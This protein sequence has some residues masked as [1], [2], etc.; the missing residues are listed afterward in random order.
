ML[1]LH[2]VLIQNK[3]NSLKPLL[4]DSDLMDGR[5]LFCLKAEALLWYT[6]RLDMHKKTNKKKNGGHEIV[7]KMVKNAGGDWQHL[8]KQT[9]NAGGKRVKSLFILNASKVLKT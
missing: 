1:L 4:V 7:L 5:Q 8:K 2:T 6:V 9:N 3:M